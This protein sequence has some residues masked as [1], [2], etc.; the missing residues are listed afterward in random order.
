MFECYPYGKGNK[1]VDEREEC[2]TYDIP[3]IYFE[4]CVCTPKLKNKL[5][6]HNVPTQ[7]HVASALF[8]RVKNLIFKLHISMYGIPPAGNIRGIFTENFFGLKKRIFIY[9]NHFL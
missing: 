4:F 7:K 1:I 9:N 8:C 3:C 5:L 2:G 6:Q